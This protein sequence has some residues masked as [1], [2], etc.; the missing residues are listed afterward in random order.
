MISSKRFLIKGQRK[1][2]SKRDY[3]HHL[4]TINEKLTRYSES[5]LQSPCILEFITKGTGTPGKGLECIILGVSFV[6]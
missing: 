3:I 4:H 1:H 5:V 2:T 6:W